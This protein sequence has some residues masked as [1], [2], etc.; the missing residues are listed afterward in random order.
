[1]LDYDK[2]GK[3]KSVDKVLHPREIFSVLTKKNK[4]FSYLRDVQSEVL[5][6]WVEQQNKK[7]LV[8]KMNTGSGKTVVGL[9]L[10]KSCLNQKIGPAVYVTP[11]SY[12]VKQV[13]NEAKDL[14]LD[15]TD[16]P[17][18]PDFKKS[19]SVLVINI[20]KLINGKSVFGV[21]SEGQKIE[22]GSILI[23]DAHACLSASQNQF[24][25]NI[26]A[27]EKS[28][29]ELLSLFREDLYKQ[30]ST[31]LL[32]IE[33]SDPLKN[34]QVP[35]WSWA[36][37]IDKVTKILFSLKDQEKCKFVWP[38]LKDHLILCRCVVSG[39]EIE[40]SP[41]CLP[42]D[43]I[44]SFVNSKRRIF[45]T[46]TLTD[47][48]VLVSDFNAEPKLIT[49]H[50]TPKK[51][52]DIGD[53]LI[54]IPQ[55]L[56][57]DY[58][59]EELKNLIKEV[60]KKNNI[61]IIVPSY[62]RA[63]FWSDI[64]DRTLTADN[65]HDG[66][67][68]LKKN[69]VGV[70]VLINR[71][72]G[73]DLPNDACRILVIDGLPDVRRRID[74]VEQITLGGS[75]ESQR[76]QIQRIEQ[77]MGRGVRSNDDYCVV[78]L[79]GANLVNELYSGGAIEKFSPGTRAQLD[80]SS[81][82]AE[83]LRGKKISNIIDVIGIFLERE[84]GWLEVSKGALVD[85]DYPSTGY[86]NPFVIAQRAAFDYA[87]VKQ[88]DRACDEM[89]K[90]VN[91]E[92]DK[93]IRGWLKQQLAEYKHFLNPVEAQVILKSAVT[94]NKYVL[95]PLDGINYEKVTCSSTQAMNCVN[96]LKKY[97]NKKNELLIHIESLLE[98]LL[99][100]PES[101]NKFEEALKQ[102]A[103]FLGFKGQ[104]PES[105]FG[106]GPDVLWAI[107][108][109]NYLVIE[110]KSGA[111]SDTI[112]K[113]NCNQLNGSM[114]WFEEKYDKSCSAT[115]LLIHPVNLFEY[116][117]SPHAKTRIITKE[118]MSDL[119]SAIKN[120]IKAI[121]SEQKMDEQKKIA[122]LLEHFNLSSSRIL[123]QFTQSFKI[124]SK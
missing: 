24:T 124:K 106:K 2:L 9:L 8:I 13:I 120:F 73:I 92:A 63:E 117:S 61:V 99:L 110:C 114:N 113:H 83:Q 20:Y 36:D 69:H 67:D 76:R 19:K 32:E 28:Y 38:L 90:I 93:Q 122:Q 72:D 31:G 3:T 6:Q 87:S 48:S 86:I 45:M 46:A 123:N 23:D 68:Q 44:P 18:S 56:A 54:L 55:E 26:P 71:Y 40:I 27:S 10:L 81:R 116:A 112:S 100:S 7:D 64:A 91:Q 94:D 88:F 111:T 70:V 59:A 47:D 108:N 62:F 35:F 52:N 78:I 29:A 115:P 101:V 1:M 41:R 39:S 50:I 104:R 97:E 75:N 89:E 30:S 95:H 118:K 11:D 80:L 43:S 98:M 51:A 15:V 60:S 58:D 57:P 49:Q 14:G 77:G 85:L 109:L 121:T 103:F 22:M 84:S 17:T 53:R 25:L 96:I 65:L 16:D 74:K 107:G 105:E 102:I 79:L 119:R 37:K 34:M 4:R 21:G 42:I 82:V 5:D 33:E 12:L 66:V